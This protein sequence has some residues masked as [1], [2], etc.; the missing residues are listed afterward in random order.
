MPELPA[1]FIALPPDDA[2]PI[3][4]VRCDDGES[5]NKY[6]YVVGQWTYD[7]NWGLASTSEIFRDETYS[8]YTLW[9]LATKDSDDDHAAEN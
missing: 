3:K 5:Y 4:F 2:R 9:R 7:D 1:A 6:I 8:I